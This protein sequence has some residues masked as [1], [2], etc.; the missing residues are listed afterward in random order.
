MID[1]PNL[2]RVLFCALLSGPLL[3]LAVDERPVPVTEE[4]MHKTVFANDA[5]R[6]IDV[7]IHPGETTKYHVHEIPSVVV[8]LSKSTNRS[9]SPGDPNFLDRSISPGESRYAPY[10]VKPLTHRVTNTGAADFHVF[11][12]EL[13]HKK[14]VAASAAAALPSGAKLEWEE[15]LARM[16]TLKV[17]PKDH[18]AVAADDCSHLLIGIKGAVATE[19]RGGLK[20]GDYTYFPARTK[21]EVS[22]SDG[23]PAEALLLELR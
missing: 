9:Q 19:K 15:K 4:P 12:I 20:L 5:I 22:S 8:Y 11:D 2:L 10:D 17:G 6:I 13:L 14:P 1:N 7:R 3:A 21:F 16:S 23:S 18:V